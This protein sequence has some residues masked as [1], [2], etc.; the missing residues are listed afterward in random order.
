MKRYTLEIKGRKGNTIATKIRRTVQVG[1]LV[2][3][4]RDM[5]AE[6]K[7]IKSI[8]IRDMLGNIIEVV[9]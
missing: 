4:A 8:E 6:D 1:S 5:M 7:K 2:G 3:Q 9:K